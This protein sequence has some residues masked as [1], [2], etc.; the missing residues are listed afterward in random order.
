MNKICLTLL[1][2]LFLLLPCKSQTLTDGKV[3]NYVQKMYEHDDFERAYSVTVSGDTIVNGLLCKKLVKVYQDTPNARI[4]YARF[5]KDSKVYGVYGE[6]TKLLM[7]FSLNVGDKA[8]EVGTVV[9]VDSVDIDNVQHKRITIDYS[10]YNY[11]SYLVEGIGL[12]STKYSSNEL[13]SYYEVLVSVYDKGK[14]IFK[15]SD[16]T[17]QTTGIVCKPQI[18]RINNSTVY[19]LCG[20]QVLIP[21]KGHVYVKGNKKVLY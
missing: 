4:V 3:W 6:E 18:E 12:S 16:F 15:N 8:N 17:K 13:N 1:G 2:A 14:C 11:Q 21:K 9:S 20:K 7:D 5:E 10:F 19:D